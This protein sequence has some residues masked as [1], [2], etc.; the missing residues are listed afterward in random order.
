M[1]DS[2]KGT[3]AGFFSLLLLFCRIR[4]H[5][6]YLFVFFLCR[7]KIPYQLHSSHNQEPSPPPGLVNVSFVNNGDWPMAVWK[8]SV[9]LS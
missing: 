6:C 1:K 8:Y 9:D 2:T 3:K 4:S 7:L 5:V